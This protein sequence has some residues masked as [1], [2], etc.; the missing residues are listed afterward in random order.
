MGPSHSWRRL[1]PLSIDEATYQSPRTK[2]LDALDAA[3]R[4]AQVQIDEVRQGSLREFVNRLVRSWAIETGILERL[5]DLDEGATQTLIEHGFRAEMVDR[6]GSSLPPEDLVAILTDQVDAA[7]MVQS[8]IREQRPLSAFFIRELHAL[9]TRHQ[10]TVTSQT[11][12]GQ[13]VEAPMLHGEWKRLPNNPLRPNGEGHQY[14]PP[15]QVASEIDRLVGA[16]NELTDVPQVVAGAWLHHRF[17]QIHPFQDGNGRVARA[18]TNLVFIR[19]GLFPLVVHRSHRVDYISALERADAGDLG[20]LIDLFAEIQSDTVLRALSFSSEERE[21]TV[22]DDVV[23]RLKGK[24][25]AK[26]RDRASALRQVNP[27][28]RDLRDRALTYLQAR[29]QTVI[30]ELAAVDMR[31][32]VYQ[33]SGGTDLVTGHYWRFQLIRIA[34]ELQHWVNFE[35]D[36]YW[37]R[38]T[39]AGAPIRFQYVV[40]LHHV[41]RELSGVMRTV[42]FVELRSDRPDSPESPGDD[43]QGERVTRNCTPTV[44]SATWQDE[45]V[46]VWPQ[47]ENWLEESFAMALRYWTDTL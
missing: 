45:P 8:L 11:V 12:A 20:P 6:A 30:Q 39:I 26:L 13:S 19:G 25:G 16:F 29:A 47:L 17:T 28:A 34:N 40:S 10:H 33:Q 2:Q 27:L 5:Y 44:F 22:V 15:E 4:Q 43:D 3:W 41:G 31:L 38:I 21:N 32:R 42:A 18:L 23:G 14:A 46:E 37:L 36:H 35:E 24:L 7:A 1:A 9:T